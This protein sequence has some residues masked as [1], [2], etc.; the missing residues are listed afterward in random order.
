[1]NAERAGQRALL[2][3][4]ICQQTIEGGMREYRRKRAA[5]T[6]RKHEH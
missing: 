1:M 4:G 5:A 6:G 3:R 2:H